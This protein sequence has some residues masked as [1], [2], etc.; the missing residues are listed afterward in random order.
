MY[1]FVG[2]EWAIRVVESD[3][4]FVDPETGRYEQTGP[5]LVGEC[6]DRIAIRAPDGGHLCDLPGVTPC[7]VYASGVVRYTDGI[8]R[9]A[10]ILT[11]RTPPPGRVVVVPST[12]TTS[13]TSS[14]STTTST[15]SASASASERSG[16]SV[17][18]PGTVIAPGVVYPSARPGVPYAPLGDQPPPR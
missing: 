3:D 7:P 5:C 11:Q 17:P 8:V 15:T 16:T 1:R 2:T 10:A 9:A 12:T 13:S 4:L 14:T 18:A 6:L